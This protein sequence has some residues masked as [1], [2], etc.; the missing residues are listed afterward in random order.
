MNISIAEDN[1]SFTVWHRIVIPMLNECPGL[2]HTTIGRTKRTTQL[3]SL[4][5]DS[6]PTL[7]LIQAYRS[8]EGDHSIASQFIVFGAQEHMTF[9][10][11][12]TSVVS[13]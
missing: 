8:F 5:V 1:D 13:E 4:I 9:T 10:I 2:E 12:I 6:L 11:I 7:S 3:I